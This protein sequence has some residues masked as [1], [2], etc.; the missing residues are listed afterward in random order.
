M[1]RKVSLGIALLL[2]ALAFGWLATEIGAAEP[3][4]KFDYGLGLRVRQEY[5]ENATDLNLAGL[6]EENYF[7]LKTSLWGK[8]QFTEKASLYTKL[9]NESRYYINSN[10]D[11]FD[12]EWLGDEVFFDNLYLD[13][14]NLAGGALDLRLGRQDFLGTFGEGF[15][16]MDGTPGDGSRSFYFNAAKAT[17]RINERNSLDVVFLNNPDQDE[18][19]PVYNDKEKLLNFSDEAALILY[20]RLQNS[21]PLRFEPY[22]IYKTED[23]RGALPDLEI[24]TLGLRTVYNQGPW[25]LGGELAYQFGDYDGPTDREGTGL[26]LFLNRKFEA[27]RLQPELQFKFVYLSGDDAGTVDN[28]G[29]DPLFSRFPWLSELYLYNYAPEQGWPGYW[30]NLTFYRAGVKL[31]LNPKLSLTFYENYL[32]ANEK[33]NLASAVFS[34]DGRERGWLSQLW[35]NFVINPK[36]TGHLQ[37]EYLKPGDFY[38]AGADPCAFLRWEF[39]IQ[40]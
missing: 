30:T 13:L 33:T 7:R 6:E 16:V 9:T 20:G 18:F 34:N 37:L 32:R 17:W 11:R 3:G 39:N 19:L 12:N 38:S 40:F 26:N 8:W 4:G 35:L 36:V 25:N 29:F 14:K 5:L 15:L 28:E 31:N 22:Y 27:A 21:E 23:S 24:N 2:V 10:T 1:G